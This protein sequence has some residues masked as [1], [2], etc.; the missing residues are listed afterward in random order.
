MR[1]IFEKDVGF[2]MVDFFSKTIFFTN[3]VAVGDLGVKIAQ[4]ILQQRF[5]GVIF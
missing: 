5:L 4:K 1:S 3:G 2:G